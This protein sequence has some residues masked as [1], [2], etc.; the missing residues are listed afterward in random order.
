MKINF[1]IKILLTALILSVSSCYVFLN[2]KQAY[3]TAPDRWI[4]IM[5][6]RHPTRD[7]TLTCLNTYGNFL[8]TSSPEQLRETNEFN[9]FSIFGSKGTVD[10]DEGYMPNVSARIKYVTN[11][12]E[13]SIGESITDFNGFTIVAEDDA[14]V[15]SNGKKK[16]SISE[17]HDW[18]AITSNGFFEYGGPAGEVC[19]EGWQRVMWIFGLRKSGMEY[20]KPARQHRYWKWC[21]SPIAYNSKEFEVYSIYI[22]KNEV[23]WRKRRIW[24]TSVDEK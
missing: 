1:P 6:I 19:V 10:I 15:V 3:G 13:L 24:F 7:I 9:N 21:I 5:S 20:K 16:I 23:A 11:E 4:Y 22:P 2:Q 14:F 12:V 8:S 17:N 18:S